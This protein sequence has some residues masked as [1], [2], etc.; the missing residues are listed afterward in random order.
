MFDINVQGFN[1]KRIADTCN[2]RLYL[3]VSVTKA[4]VWAIWG[5]QGSGSDVRFNI[6]YYGEGYLGIE[7]Y[8]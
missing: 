1:P 2:F 4:T 3:S 8:S 6:K 5:N 7:L